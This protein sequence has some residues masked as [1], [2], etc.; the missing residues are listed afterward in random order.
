MSSLRILSDEQL[1]SIHDASLTVLEETGMEVDHEQARE[2]LRAS[3]A[4][5]DHDRKMVRFRPV[6][7]HPQLPQDVSRELERI[8]ASGDQELAGKA[9]ASQQRD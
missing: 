9:A 8:V 6:T 4:V 5:V 1:R 7:G 3:G 2:I